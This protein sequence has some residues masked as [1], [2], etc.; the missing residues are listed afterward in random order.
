MHQP[1]CAAH[2]AFILA[3]GSPRRKELTEQLGWVPVVFASQIPEER[4]PD[5]TPIAYAERLARQKA[6]AVAAEHDGRADLPSFILAADTIVMLDDAVLE[7]PVDVEDAIR[8]LIALSGTTHEVVTSL[9][10]LRRRDGATRVRT[11]RTEV[12][13]REVDEETI[14]RY[15]ATGEPMDKA[16]AYGIQGLG[17]ALVARID[18][19]YSSV[20][21]LPIAATVEELEA[22]DGLK[23]FPFATHQEEV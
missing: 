9:C 18:G 4:G 15:V 21:G 8:M 14:A 22:L 2:P 10:W 16:G 19:S 13:M 12:Q 5:E 3:S 20:V 23:D 1:I 17:G 11:V 7:K 6:E